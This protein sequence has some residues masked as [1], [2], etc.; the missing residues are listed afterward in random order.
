MVRKNYL[1]PEELLA[2]LRRLV[3]SGRYSTESEAVRC[4]LK[5]LVEAERLQQKQVLQRLDEL[6]EKTAKF[7]PPDKTAGELV[8]E[9]HEEEAHES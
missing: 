4:A 9:A 2:E 7:L 5:R 1:I 8:H 6:A 3:A